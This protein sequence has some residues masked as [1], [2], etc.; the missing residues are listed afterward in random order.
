MAR[1]EVPKIRQAADIRKWAKVRF[2]SR[3]I[4]GPSWGARFRIARFFELFDER[5]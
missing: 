1:V 4:S 2:F 3:F 5:Q